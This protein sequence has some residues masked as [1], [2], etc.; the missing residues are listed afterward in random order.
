MSVIWPLIIRQFWRFCLIGVGNT[1]IDAGWYLWFTRQWH[2][3]YALANVGAFLVANSCSFWLNRTWTFAAAGP[4]RVPYQ[5]FLMVSLIALVVVETT[6]VVGVQW[7]DKSDLVSKG[8][9]IGV[10]IGFSFLAHRQ[11]SFRPAGQ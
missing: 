8:V 10:S 5:R 3:H 9:A 4:A 6:L 7:L 1:V 11:W 2:W